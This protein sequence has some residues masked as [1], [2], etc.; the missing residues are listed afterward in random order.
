[1][2]SIRKG[3]FETNSS[4]TH[5]IVIERGKMNFE[6]A[7]ERCFGKKGNVILFEGGAFGW[8]FDVADNVQYLWTAILQSVGEDN[9]DDL[10]EWKKYISHALGVYGYQ[11]EFLLP[12]EDDY[13]YIDH[14]WALGDFIGWIAEDPD[15]LI[16][17]L[18]SGEV[19]TGNDNDGDIDYPCYYAYKTYW[20][21]CT[22][23]SYREILNPNYDEKKYIYFFKG[24]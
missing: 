13:W 16:R 19:Y 12:T 14:G 5:S 8:E 4:S 24:N 23:G 11:A 20:G 2:Y 1:M 10:E 18:V 15:N 17:Y 3:V 21:E 9:E 7:L 22:D 6:E